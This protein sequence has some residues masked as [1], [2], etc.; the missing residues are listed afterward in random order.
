MHW[1]RADFLATKPEPEEWTVCPAGYALTLNTHRAL[2]SPIGIISSLLMDKY[3]LLN[4]CVH[5]LQLRLSPLALRGTLV[6]AGII[7]T[8]D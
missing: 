1:W 8:D 2:N 4:W 7:D 6:F 5:H 3:C